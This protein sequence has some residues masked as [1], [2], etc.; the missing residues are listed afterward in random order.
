LLEKQITAN[1]RQ[2]NS[3][4]TAGMKNETRLLSLEVKD[5]RQ[6][7]EISS[8]RVYLL[9]ACVVILLAAFLLYR[10]KSNQKLQMFELQNKISQDLH[11]DVGSSLSSLQVYSSVATQ[12]M[13]DQP[14]KAKEMLRK[15]SMQSA[16]LMENIGD[17]V[18]SMKTEN[19]QPLSER[20]K[21][22]VSDVLGAANINYQVIIE[23]GTEAMIRNIAA[24]KNILLIV[25]EAINN[26]TKYSHAHQVVVNIKKLGGQLCLMI[27]DDGVGIQSSLTE[28]K[29]V[30]LVNMKRR[31]E[32][33][34][35]IFGITSAPG[36]GTTIS[37]LFP[38]T[39]IS[40]MA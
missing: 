24:R 33:L 14:A 12:L 27:T 2:V 3:I 36:K 21:N 13:E 31:T 19:E 32:E 16:S 4:L 9:L 37:A 23:E 18:W 22:F 7:N 11:D 25:K 10:Y 28:K 8:I 26:A 15:I 40:D 38:L 35:G 34:G 39:T 29:A 20:I 1:N 17:I 30:G 6:R 5:A